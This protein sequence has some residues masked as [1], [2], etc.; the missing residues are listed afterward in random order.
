[1]TFVKKLEMIGFKS[2]PTKTDLKFPEGVSACVGPNGSGKSNVAE[3][4]NFVIGKTSKKELRAERLTDFIWN[5][6]KKGKPSN[7]AK[8]KITF[9]ND[10]KIFPVNDSE[11]RI[12]RKVSPKGSIYT[13]NGER[14]TRE[15][16]LSVLAHARIDPDGHNII[17]QGDIEKFV[18]MDSIERRKIIEEISGIAIYEEKK[19]RSILNLQKVGDKIKEASIILTEKKKLLDELQEQKDKAERFKKVEK[20]LRVKQASI[21]HKQMLEIRKEEDSFK[22]KISSKEGQIDTYNSKIEKIDSDITEVKRDIEKVVKETREKGFEQ[23][24]KIRE[25]VTELKNRVSNQESTIDNITE[26]IKRAKDGQ[27]NLK[28]D[29]QSQTKELGVEKKKLAFIQEQ[30][31]TLRDSI[32]SQEREINRLLGKDAGFIE[33]RKEIDETR[34][35]VYEKRGLLNQ[36]ESKKNLLSRANDI[37][38]ELGTKKKSVPNLKQEIDV[39]QNKVTSLISKERE[40][41]EKIRASKSRILQLDNKKRIYYDS[42]NQGTKAILRLR[43]SK[44]IEGIVGTIHEL[45]KADSKY[46]VALTVSLGARVNN[47]LVRN[48]NVAKKCIQYLRDNKRGYATF[49]P[50]NK[51]RPFNAFDRGIM[52]DSD[53]IGYA[54]DLIETKYRE[55]FSSVLRDTLIVKDF[56]TAKRVGIG[57]YRMVSLDGDLFEKSGSITGGSRLVERTLGLLSREADDQLK[58]HRVELVEY[59]K[60]F[61]NITK[62]LEQRKKHLEEKREEKAKFDAEIDFLTTSL[63]NIEKEI[64]GFKLIDYKKIEN[65]V[66]LL[67]TKLTKLKKEHKPLPKVDD[68]T[69]TKKQMEVEEQRKD[70]SKSLKQESDLNARIEHALGKDIESIIELIEKAKQQEKEFQNK[71]KSS[72]EELSSLK[73]QLEVEMKTDWKNQSKAKKR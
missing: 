48:E 21:L 35:N 9:D 47:I 71:L 45:G 6:G 39:L 51:I 58:K 10:S 69:I 57:R 24:S 20:E 60:Y 5:G 36:Y 61:R 26:Q 50:K 14:T 23:A 13:I 3:A 43:E 42:L 29:M 64:G 11:L 68:K 17:M 2:F 31:K 72:K 63:S 32:A 67:E 25:K 22:N 49:L 52:K 8:V 44:S 12:S 30:V 4:I 28:Q 40:S 7:F 46:K 55:V 19:R 38:S 16:V 56:N 37:E 65:E 54:V 15:E 27:T 53:V 66:M 33:L 34:E 59:E 73:K 1:M 41:E 62:D 70:L 18:T